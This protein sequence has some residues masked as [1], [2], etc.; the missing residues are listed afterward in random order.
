MPT[1]TTKPRQPRKKR[2][3]ANDLAWR[4]AIAAERKAWLAEHPGRTSVEYT[5]LKNDR[6]FPDNE[7]GQWRLARARKADKAMRRAWLAEHPGDPLPEHLCALDNPYKG[8]KRWCAAAIR[9]I[10]NYERSR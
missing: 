4:A 1:K 5:K 9:W 10:D 3:S 2:I 6:I 7:L 8:H